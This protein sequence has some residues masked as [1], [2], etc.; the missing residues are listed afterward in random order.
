MERRPDPIAATHAAIRAL[1]HKLEQM[2]LAWNYSA[3]GEQRAAQI[4][5][6]AAADVARLLGDP[7]QEQ[8]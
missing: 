6:Q 2:A 5:K 3:P 7:A 4:F 8:P 1:Q